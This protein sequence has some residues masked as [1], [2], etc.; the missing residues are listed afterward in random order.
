M[1]VLSGNGFAIVASKDTTALMKVFNRG[2]HPRT[3]SLY[4]DAIEAA[5][6]T[7]WKAHWLGSYRL[8]EFLAKNLS[9]TKFHIS[10]LKWNLL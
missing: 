3:P 1:F 8:G 4:Q 9:Q 5:T 2:F 10:Q 6:G 7:D